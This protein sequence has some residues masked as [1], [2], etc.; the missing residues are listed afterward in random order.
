MLGA[1][2]D[3]Q[4]SWAKLLAADFADLTDLSDDRS[5]EADQ[6]RFGSMLEGRLQMIV[7]QFFP[8]TFSASS[9]RLGVSAVSFS[10]QSRC[11]S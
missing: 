6:K 3:L 11:G 1:S 7:A 9:L 10:V 8:T 4:E 2:R 5:C